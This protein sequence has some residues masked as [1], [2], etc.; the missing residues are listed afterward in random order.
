[1]MGPAIR[2]ALESAGHEWV[3][4]TSVD[5]SLANLLT[6]DGVFLAGGTAPPDTLQ[7][8]VQ[9]G[10]NV[11]IAGG[12]GSGGADAE[13]ARYNPFLASFGLQLV[14]PYN[15]AQLD[16]PISSASP[17]L[18]G[19]DHLYAWGAHGLTDLTPSDPSSVLIL[20]HALLKIGIYDA[21][22]PLPGDTNCD[23]SVNLTDLST[24]LA[25]F[26]TP[27]G[28]DRGDGDLDGDGDVDLSDLSVLL[29]VFGSS[30]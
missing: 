4:S 19:V 10:G 27:S 5:T 24:L 23:C 30:C 14:G 12:T 17:L 8:Y 29:S 26:G 15:N 3:V 1:M 18:A 11:Y 7:A 2:S 21:A 20:D 25:N 9:A 6:Y 28:A 22:C 16:V 13:A